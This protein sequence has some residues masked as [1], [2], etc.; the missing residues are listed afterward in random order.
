M[1]MLVMLLLALVMVPVL[2][3]VLVLLLVLM[4]TVLALVAEGASRRTG[5]GPSLDV[6]SDTVPGTG[7]ET[8]AGPGAGADVW[9]GG[10][11]LVV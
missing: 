5:W 10:M 1:L 11:L 6:T 7:A 8:G 2:A 9:P 3:L 4:G